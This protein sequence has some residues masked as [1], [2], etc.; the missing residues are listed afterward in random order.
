MKITADTNVLVSATFWDG[1]S[2]KIIEKVERKEIELVLSK[3]ILEE[4]AAVLGYREMQDKIKNKN[5]E[6]KRTIER[7]AAISTIAEPKQKFEIVKEDPDD[8]KIIDC[9][10]A[11]NVDYIVTND[12]HL[13]NLKNIGGIVVIT[14]EELIQLTKP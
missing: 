11:G 14:P 1:E 12:H 9:A 5:L 2:N 4:F 7:I 6:M 10:K 3:E 8:N 13:L